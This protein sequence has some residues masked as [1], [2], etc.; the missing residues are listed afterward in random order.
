[1]TKPLSLALTASSV[2]LRNPVRFFMFCIGGQISIELNRNACGCC[3]TGK[4]LQRLFVFFQLRFLAEHGNIALPQFQR[5]GL[6]SI[7]IHQIAPGRQ[8]RLSQL[9]VDAS[10]CFKS[11]LGSCQLVH[12]FAMLTQSEVQGRKLNIL[13]SQLVGHCLNLRGVSSTQLVD[14]IQIFMGK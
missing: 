2:R 7:L 10:L 3:D 9:T 4:H 8:K 11:F 12:I 1:M 5:Y 14:A 6:I 13:L